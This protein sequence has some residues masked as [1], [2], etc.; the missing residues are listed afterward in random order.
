MGKYEETLR[1]IERTLGKI[2]GF[3]KVLPGDLLIRDWPSWK[4][5]RPGEMEL[6]RASYMLS[7]DEMYEEILAKIQSKEAGTESAAFGGRHGTVCCGVFVDMGVIA[8]AAMREEYPVCGE[9]CR[10]SIEL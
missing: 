9:N 10:K 3:M 4:K 6:E 1:D 8:P 5:D 7:T 2:P